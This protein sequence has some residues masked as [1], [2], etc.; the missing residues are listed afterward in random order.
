MDGIE[1]DKHEQN[2]ESWNA[3]TPFHN[4][5]K[6]DQAAFFRSGGSTLFPEELE[7][8]GDLSGKRVLHLQCNCGQDTLSLAALGAE[9]VGVDISDAAIAFATQLASDSGLPA[10]FVRS[11]VYD[12]FDT[13][14]E[15][16]DVVFASYGVIG[17]L[18]N[19]TK[20]AEGIAAALR[21]EGAFVMMEFHS[22]AFCFDEQLKLVEPYSTGGDDL[23]NED[24]IRDYVQNSMLAE[25]APRAKRD[26][27]PFK[28]PHP[29]FGFH[30]GVGDTATAILHAGLQLESLQEF[31]YSNGCRVNRNCVDVGKRRYALPDHLPSFPMMFAVKASKPL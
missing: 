5:H 8:L 31:Q 13:N 18:S 30:W 17:W 16:F 21:P 27:A 9:V 3:V 14:E 19:L 7:M 25:F 22:L 20:W 23:P 4:R 12:W 28:N 29:Y 26:P 10:T 2:R 24:G 1:R 11:D 15:T 6:G